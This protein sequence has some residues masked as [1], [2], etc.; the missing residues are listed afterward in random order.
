MPSQPERERE[1]EKERERKKDREKA[2]SN[3]NRANCCTWPLSFCPFVQKA[4]KVA[5]KVES[6]ADVGRFCALNALLRWLVLAHF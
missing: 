2:N 5:A 3:A 6:T 4:A 1:R